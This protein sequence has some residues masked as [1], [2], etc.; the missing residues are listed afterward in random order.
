MTHYALKHK[1]EQIPRSC[2]GKK[3]KIAYFRQSWFKWSC[4]SH[5][6]SNKLK[7]FHFTRYSLPLKVNKNIWVS[8][9]IIAKLSL[10]CGLTQLK[11]RIHSNSP[12]KQSTNYNILRIRI[13]KLITGESYHFR[14]FLWTNIMFSEVLEQNL[15]I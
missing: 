1:Q 8:Y 3:C 13:S 15:I 7:F 9:W 4:G 11:R 10:V 6:A 14:P 12:N 2:S 5:E